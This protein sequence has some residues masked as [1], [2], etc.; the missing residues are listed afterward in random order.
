[1]ISLFKVIRKKSILLELQL[2]Q[3]IKIH[4]IFY[5]NLLQKVLIDL[6][7]GQVNKLILPVIINNKE[8]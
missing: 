3:T 8:K 5:L 6:L 1:M 2:L 7:T 4:N